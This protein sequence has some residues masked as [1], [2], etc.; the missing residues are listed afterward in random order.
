MVKPMNT[1]EILPMNYSE[2]DPVRLELGKPKK[3]GILQT[4]GTISAIITKL[5]KVASLD[6]TSF[7]PSTSLGGLLQ[8]DSW[9]VGSKN[10]FRE[11]L[12][13]PYIQ[14]EDW[15]DLAKCCFERMTE[16][17]VSGIVITMGTDTLGYAAAALSIMLQHSTIPIVLT[18]SM[19]APSEDQSDAHTNLLDACLAAALVPGGIYVAFGGKLLFGMDAAKHSSLLLEAY[20]ARSGTEAGV[21]SHKDKSVTLC[22]AFY[23]DLGTPSIDVR[24]DNRVKLESIYPGYEPKWLERIL[25]SEDIGCVILEGYGLGHLP[26][27]GMRSLAPLLSQFSSKKPI[28]ALSQCLHSPVDLKQYEEGQLADKVG[29]LSSGSLSRECVTFLA[30][31]I[32]ART[33]STSEFK[34]KWNRLVESYEGPTGFFKI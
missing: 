28:I 22:K 29:V 3:I 33:T 19:R 27:K 7:F 4:G 2:K 5:G 6:V 15:Q 9:P 10:G 16:N 1:A 23:P 18:G 11:L 21:I 31:A 14:P 26:V 20:V 30:K 12:L 8:I 34:V 17:S 13:S 32:L 24:F 25:N